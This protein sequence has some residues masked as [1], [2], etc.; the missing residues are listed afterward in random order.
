M[1]IPSET[2]IDIP[3]AMEGTREVPFFS[4]KSHEKGGA[5]VR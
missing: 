4:Q 2:G 3:G 5:F 1:P